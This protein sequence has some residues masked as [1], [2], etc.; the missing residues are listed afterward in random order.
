MKV[1]HE[2]IISLVRDT[3][4]KAATTFSDDKKKAYA[5]ALENENS[6]TAKEVLELITKNAEIA[7]RNFFPLCDDT[8]IPHIVLEIGPDVSISGRL[9]DSIKIGIA[10]GLKKLP[11]RPM[12]LVGDDLSRINQS[13]G[14]SPESADVLPAPFLLTETEENVLRIHILMFG[15]GP[16]IR[17]TT[18]RIFHK[19][20][21]EVV[22]DEI[23][24]RST[25][26][27]AQLG[28]SPCTLAIGIGRSHF[29]AAALMLM[30]QAKGRYD[31]QS[32]WEKEITE[33]VNRS[34]IGA[35]GLPGKIGVLATFIQV[36]EQRASGVRIVCIRPACCHEPRIA[37]AELLRSN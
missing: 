13:G 3:L 6:E 17:A 10:E 36:G 21:L 35:L 32:D 1:N 29:E 22:T 11:G 30:S 2:K 27:V 8:G 18:Y 7:E 19:H 5:K 25:E 16:A 20:S 37:S 4:L 26:A 31:V 14:L 34:G 33:K 23:V 9:L 12:A 28:C 15:G 24:K